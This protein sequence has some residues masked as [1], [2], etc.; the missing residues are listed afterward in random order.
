MFT[1]AQFDRPL[2]GEVRLLDLLNLSLTLLALT[3]PA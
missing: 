1:P 2:A 3:G